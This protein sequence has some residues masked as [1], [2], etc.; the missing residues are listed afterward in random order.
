MAILDNIKAHWRMEEA[1]G[2][3]RADTVGSCTLAEYNG[4]VA[5]TA[6]RIGSYAA[7]ANNASSNNY[8]RRSVIEESFYPAAAGAYTITA[9]VKRT[10]A[11][12]TDLGVNIFAIAGNVVPISLYF[13]GYAGGLHKVQVFQYLTGGPGP[14]LNGANNLAADTWHFVAMKWNG[15]TLYLYVN[16]ETAVSAGCAGIYPYAS[17]TSPVFRTLRRDSNSYG[18]AVDSMT[19]WHRALSDSEIAGIRDGALDY[20]F[21]TDKRGPFP[22]HFRV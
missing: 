9:W 19:W 17:L 1:A 22:L 7:F 20:P 8:L 15:S 4:Q 3:S 5:Q 21:S 2:S 12:A 10:T 6:G 11:F 14:T 13:L 16:S 18:V